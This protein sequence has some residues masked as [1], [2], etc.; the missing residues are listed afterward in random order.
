VGTIVHPYGREILRA[1]AD[2]NN[3]RRVARLGAGFR[4]AFL[5]GIDWRV[6]WRRP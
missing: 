6:R 3:V 2:G 1:N 4:L 5:S